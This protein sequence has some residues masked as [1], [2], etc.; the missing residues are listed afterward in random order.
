[1]LHYRKTLLFSA[2]IELRFLFGTADDLHCKNFVI[3][4]CAEVHLLIGTYDKR[5]CKIPLVFGVCVTSFIWHCKC[6]ALQK[7]L[8]LAFVLNYVFCLALL[9]CYML[10]TSYIWSWS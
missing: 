8:Y 7:K 2:C 3:G 5:H 4:V 6:A 10:Q 9:M 1:M